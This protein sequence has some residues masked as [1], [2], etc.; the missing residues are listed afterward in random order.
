MKTYFAHFLISIAFVFT[1]CSNGKYEATIAHYIQSDQR[2]RLYDL[3]FKMIDMEQ[4]EP[5][6]VQDSIKIITALQNDKIKELEKRIAKDSTELSKINYSIWTIPAINDYKARLAANTKERD[7]LKTID[8]KTV[9]K[10][11]ERKQDEVLAIRFRCTYS[12]LHPKTQ[13]K[14]TETGEY[15]LSPDGN[16]VYHAQLE[17]K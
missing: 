13:I 16:Q 15:V 2:G 1:A 12:Y 11:N 5:I 6:T 3:D 9:F 14:V 4:T 8:P 7:W 10:Y 17:K